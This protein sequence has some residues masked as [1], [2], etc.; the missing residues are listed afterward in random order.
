MAAD[1]LFAPPGEASRLTG[2]AAL[3]TV[4]AGDAWAFAVSDLGSEAVVQS[5][6]AEVRRS[7]AST[8]KIAHTLLALD[9][10]VVPDTSA[11]LG[12]DRAAYPREAWWPAT[13]TGEMPVGAAFRRSA[14]PV[15]RQIGARI[16][17]ARAQAWL[18]RVG[19]GNRTIGPD[20][21]GADADVYWLDRS[22][23]I[24]PAEQVAFVGAMWR[25]TR[26]AGDLPVSVEAARAVRDF[27][28]LDSARVPGG[29]VA[30]LYGKTGW[31]GTDGGDPAAWL[32]GAVERGGRVY[33]YAVV[34]DR[35]PATPT[36]RHD[37][38]RA[39]LRAVGVWP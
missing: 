28:R 26:G 31:T 29:G 32:V 33:P 27:M 3:D 14:V 36:E 11:M 18:D 30:V 8:Y 9:L 4:F 12:Y 10:G 20:T 38:A 2:G 1:T 34:L 39:L 25:R 23:R 7:P 13:W 24:S 35:E 22:L 37:R 15:Y 19:Y 6:S 16:G 17:R 5:A 21:S